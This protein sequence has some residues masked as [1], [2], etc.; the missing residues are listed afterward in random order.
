M[1]YPCYHSLVFYSIIISSELYLHVKCF[2]GSLGSGSLCT[3]HSQSLFHSFRLHVCMS[4]SILLPVNVD[5]YAGGSTSLFLPQ[6]LHIYVIVT[7]MLVPT[8][9][10]AVL[11]YTSGGLTHAPNNNTCQF[12][13]DTGCSVH[14]HVMYSS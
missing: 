6:S 14:C 7:L 8:L 5:I 1:F 13:I 11:S 9:V 2:P 12:S 3:C 4:L 10:C